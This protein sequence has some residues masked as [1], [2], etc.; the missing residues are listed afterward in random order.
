MFV[1]FP[2]IGVNLKMPL[3]WP[4]NLFFK[5]ELDELFEFKSIRPQ[6]LGNSEAQSAFSMA[7]MK[8]DT[9]D[10]ENPHYDP[11]LVQSFTIF[12]S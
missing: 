2:T 6:A 7:L 11:S 5:G 12:F 10:V 8:E 3:C 1:F 4:L 9:S